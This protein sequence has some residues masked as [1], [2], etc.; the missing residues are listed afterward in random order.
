MVNHDIHAI[1]QKIYGAI[2]DINQQD[3]LAAQGRLLGQVNHDRERLEQILAVMIKAKMA[4]V[5]KLHYQ[6][7]T[8]AA[9]LVNETQLIEAC[10][11]QVYRQ[12]ETDYRN[13][14]GSGYKRAEVILQ[15]WYDN[16]L[17]L[18]LND[19]AFQ[20]CQISNLENQPQVEP[21][22]EA[23]VEKPSRRAIDS[24]DYTVFNR[25]NHAVDWQQLTR[26]FDVPFILRIHFRKCEFQQVMHLV[27]SGKISD[28]AD[29]TY[30]LQSLQSTLSNKANICSEK[31]ETIHELQTLVSEKLQEK[32][33]VKNDI[34][35]GIEKF[36]S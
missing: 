28:E 7:E 9:Y 32:K 23:V 18:E 33:A 8:E 29:L 3:S 35:D 14:T 36:F 13:K 27:N 20:T 6:K 30:I 17:P 16:K 12:L 22:K 34:V 10:R 5:I 2:R 11:R 15:Q 4:F 21:E 19:Q 24:P 1:I 25:I 31:E 26:V